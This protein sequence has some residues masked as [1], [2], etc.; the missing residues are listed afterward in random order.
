[1]ST[2]TVFLSLLLTVN[3]FGQDSL[4]THL[5]INSKI[6]SDKVVLNTKFPRY[7]PYLGLG[8]LNG[9]RIG[10]L[11]QFHENFSVEAS[12]GYLFGVGWSQTD[13]DNMANIGVSIHIRDDIPVFFSLIYT[14]RIRRPSN[15]DFININDEQFASLNVGYLD[16]TEKGLKFMGRIG[17]YTDFKDKFTTTSPFNFLNIDIGLG[18]SF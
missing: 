8:T 13:A 15:P 4:K 5:K 3:V 2:L 1:M 6:N 14:W 11:V 16:L 7:F 18:Y 12:Y 10:G 17:L 9:E